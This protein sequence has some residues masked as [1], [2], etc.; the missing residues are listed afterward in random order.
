VQNILASFAWLFLEIYPYKFLKE[1]RDTVSRSKEVADSAI[2]ILGVQEFVLVVLG[3]VFCLLLKFSLR[4]WIYLAHLDPQCAGLC[5]V[6]F[7]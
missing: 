7:R 5:P 4:L 2:C 3:D 1:N 6:R